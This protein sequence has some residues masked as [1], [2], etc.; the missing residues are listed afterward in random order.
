MAFF[1]RFIRTA[2][3]PVFAQAPLSRNVSTAITS[4]VKI[5]NM[6][7]SLVVDITRVPIR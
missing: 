6:M 7:H 4:T 3:V 5:V 2:H 1:K